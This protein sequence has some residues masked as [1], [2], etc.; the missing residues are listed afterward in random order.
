V[1]EERIPI[2]RAF[3][4][5]FL[6][7]VAISGTTTFGWLY[8]LHWKETL[9]VNPK[10]AL[11]VIAQTAPQGQQLDQSFF[12]EVLGL[13][14]DEPMNLYALSKKEAER[15]LGEHPLIKTAAV[16]QL[17][18]QTLHID[19]EMR[20]PVA[21]LGDF[22]NVALDEEGIMI[23]FRPFFTPKRLPKITFGLTETVTWGNPLPDARYSLALQ[24]IEAFRKEGIEVKS[25]DL[26][27][28]EASS[29]GNR[30]I[31]AIVEEPDHRA[32]RILR[33][34]HKRPFA[35]L[36]DYLRYRSQYGDESFLTID[37]RIKDLAFLNLSK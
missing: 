20:I 16:S 8:Y 13:S 11:T 27:R 21:F 23:P 19:Y 25:L 12:A 4:W 5:V 1:G 10:Y 22:V 29:Y 15:R 9:Q 31:V 3:L 37:L 30:E 7:V 32:P 14:Q 6:S 36:E 17:P 24:L 26:S 35:S 34:N 18:P 28:M 33:L 2:K